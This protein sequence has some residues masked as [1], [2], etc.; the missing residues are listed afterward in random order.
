MQTLTDLLE[1]KENTHLN[2]FDSGKTNLE[3]LAF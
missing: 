3:Q 2:L 1:G